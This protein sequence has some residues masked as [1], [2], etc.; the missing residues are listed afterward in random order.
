[1]GCIYLLFCRTKGGQLLMTRALTYQIPNK[2]WSVL[3]DG[4]PRILL[5]FS[6][7]R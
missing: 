5:S 2:D 3:C 7:L 4:T 1:M 6:F